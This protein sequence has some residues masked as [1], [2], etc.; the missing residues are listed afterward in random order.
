[1]CIKPFGIRYG[2]FIGRRIIVNQSTTAGRLSDE[3]N[4]LANIR[5]IEFILR[6]KATDRSLISVEDRIED[7]HE[8]V[9]TLEE[10]R[11]H[12]ITRLSDGNT[13]VYNSS[14]TTLSGIDAFTIEPTTTID[15]INGW[16]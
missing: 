11:I 10:V 9:E 5:S 13:K 15:P 14:A 4:P 2:A 6:D 3:E 8:E 16:I 12:H 7:E 1:M